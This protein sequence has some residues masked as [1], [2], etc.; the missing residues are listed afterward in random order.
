[1]TNPPKSWRT[2][3]S[4]NCGILS[5]KMDRIP[6]LVDAGRC[7]QGKN[8]IGM[9]DSAGIH[10]GDPGFMLKLQKSF[11]RRILTRKLSLA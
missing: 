2:R 7:G 6:F 9:L 8:L 3:M 11:Y 10:A 4:E 5:S 1:M